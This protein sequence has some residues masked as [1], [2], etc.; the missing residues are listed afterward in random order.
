V[1]FRKEGDGPEN[2]R[3]RFVEQVDG[4]VD[5]PS[6]AGERRPRNES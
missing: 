3:P 5:R 2:E 6:L 1:Q 4:F